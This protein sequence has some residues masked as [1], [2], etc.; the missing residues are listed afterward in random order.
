MDWDH[1]LT[2]LG[3]RANDMTQTATESSNAITERLTLIPKDLLKYPTK[4]L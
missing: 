4:Y 3:A 1:T 2:F